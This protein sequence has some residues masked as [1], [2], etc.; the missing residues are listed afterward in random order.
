MLGIGK[1]FTGRCEVVKPRRRGKRH[2][3]AEI[4]ARIVA[5]SLQ[6]G[7]RVVDFAARN[8]ILPHHLLGWCRHARQGLLAL[9][10]N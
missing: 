4:T 5:E 3:L 9:P 7:V 2:W 8:D 6:P 1:G 10:T